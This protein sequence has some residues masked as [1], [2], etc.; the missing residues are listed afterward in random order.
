MA[1][2]PGEGPKM[3]WI[4]QDITLTSSF[5][6]QN[7]CVSIY[8]CFLLKMMGCSLRDVC[9][10]VSRDEGE[11]DVSFSCR[12]GE[13]MVRKIQYAHNS[14]TNSWL[15]HHVLTSKTML[16]VNCPFF[17]SFGQL[18][19][20]E[21]LQNPPESVQGVCINDVVWQTG[22]LKG[23]GYTLKLLLNATLR[24]QYPTH[25]VRHFRIHWRRLR[26]PDPRITAGPL[27]LIGRCYTNLYRVVELEMPAAPG[28]IELVVEPVTREG[29]IVPEP[30]WGR[31]TLSYSES[32]AGNPWGEHYC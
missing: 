12:I 24:W 31:R 32:S 18:L 11:E 20:A 23:D 2:L 13:I 25:L 26:G 8:S 4:I 14:Q 21:R 16:F 7:E 29:F 17:C 10:R 22:A 6:D 27:T 28:L 9:I 30:H 3:V 15:I 1:G 5:A 19:D